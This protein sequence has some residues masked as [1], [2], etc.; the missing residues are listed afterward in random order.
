MIEAVGLA[1][2]VGGEKPVVTALPAQCGKQRL[3]P[4]GVALPLRQHGLPVTPDLRL[5]AAVGQQGQGPR[6]GLPVLL[7]EGPAQADFHQLVIV[8]AIERAVQPGREILGPA[9]RPCRAMADSTR[10][11]C[12]ALKSSSA[13]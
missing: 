6:Q 1:H 8:Q 5:P 3:G 12:S 7:R 10:R 4:L 2:P 13:W 11:T 9:N